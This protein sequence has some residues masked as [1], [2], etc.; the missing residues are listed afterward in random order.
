MWN[1][2]TASIDLSTVTARYYFT[3]D[4]GSSTVN[5]WCDWAAMGC[6][7]VRWKV[8]PMSTAGTGADTYLEVSSAPLAAG[9]S[10]GEIQ[11]RFAKSDWSAFNETND[12]SYSSATTYGDYAKVTAYR[13]GTLV[14][15]TEP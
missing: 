5:V 13:S 1:T 7:N 4:A 3:R 12:Y 14:W 8:V 10:T 6:S 2:S 11:L 9:K 15:G